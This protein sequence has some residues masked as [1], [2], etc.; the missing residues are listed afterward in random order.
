MT[1][2]TVR[3]CRSLKSESFGIRASVIRNEYCC[4]RLALAAK[5]IHNVHRL[6]KLYNRNIYQRSMN[7]R[8]SIAILPLLTHHESKL[9]PTQAHIRVH[10]RTN[11]ASTHVQHLGITDVHWE[12]FAAKAELTRSVVVVLSLFS[13]NSKG[14]PL[15]S[16]EKST[17]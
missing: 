13:R 3:A 7:F 8:C 1:D 14:C 10:N 12:A 2:T 15:S 17:P 16:Q 5:Q 9:D 4:C 6:Y 11:L